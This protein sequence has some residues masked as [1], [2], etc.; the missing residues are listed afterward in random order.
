MRRY[1]GIGRAQQATVFCGPL[2]ALRIP[3]GKMS[4]F[5]MQETRLKC[6]QAAV[7]PFDI[8]IVLLRLSVVSENL[9]FVGQGLVIGRGRS[10]FS[11]SAEILAW[12]KT[13][14]CGPS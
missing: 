6:I 7:V 3:L 8:V 14:R 9:H 2:A 1:D 5:H 13:E 10:S 11:A 12:I 4:K